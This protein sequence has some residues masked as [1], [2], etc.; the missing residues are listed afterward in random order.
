MTSSGS[1]RAPTTRSA[2]PSCMYGVL[3]SHD[4]V[5]AE[6]DM[7]ALLT[8]YQLLRR[9]MVE[10]AEFR[11]GTDPDRCGSLSPS[12]PLATC[13]YAREES[14]SR[15]SGRSADESCQRCRLHGEAASARQGE[16]T[17]LPLCGE[18]I[19]RPTRQQQ[20][21]DL[22]DERSPAA[23]AA[24]ARAA[25]D[26]RPGEHRQSHGT[27]PD[28]PA[29]GARTAMAPKGDRRPPRRRHPR[30]HLSPTCPLD[31]ER[32]EEGSREFARAATRPSHRSRTPCV[33]TENAHYP[34]LGELHPGRPRSRRRQMS[35][36]PDCRPQPAAES[37]H[38]T[39]P[40]RQAA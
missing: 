35:Y 2:P 27:C 7:W 16:V 11:P 38:R 10:A 19:G 3:R 4:P 6:Q 21:R 18:G 1:T 29:G 5:G 34:A 8:L 20:G 23:P 39:W 31:R 13:W 30:R 40:R 9:T 17:H 37:H 28:H 22:D 33:T 24:A 15:A 12:K 25:R 14:S 32:K 36:S 26:D